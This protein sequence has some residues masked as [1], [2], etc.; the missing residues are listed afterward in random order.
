MSFHRGGQRRTIET[1]CGWRC[2][3][4]PTEVNKKYL[5]HKRFC[6]EC[7]D[8][9][10]ILPEYSVEAGLINGWS[11]LTGNLEQTNKIMT[12]TFVDGIRKDILVE[13]VNRI[14]DGIKDVKLL[15]SLTEEEIKELQ[16]TPVLSKS[17]QK[18]QKQKAKKEREKVEKDDDITEIYNIIKGKY[19]TE[20][21][22]PD[23]TEIERDGVIYIKM[24]CCLVEKELDNV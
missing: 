21:R 3:G 9:K 6:N 11:G 4:H 24:G 20:P 13:G 12:T 15:L 23:G 1:G 17:K 10:T 22:E 7:K 8:S 2:V 18:R 14:E 5:I 16:E 19:E